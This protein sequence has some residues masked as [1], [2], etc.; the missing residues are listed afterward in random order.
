MIRR[1]QSYKDS[2]DARD[3][4]HVYKYIKAIIKFII[5]TKTDLRGARGCR[6]FGMILN[7]LDLCIETLGA[8]NKV[9]AA[10]CKSS[11]AIWTAIIETAR[12]KLKKTE[13]STI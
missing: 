11:L 3:H 10:R 4:T 8:Q 7:L 9:Q 1:R 6:P 2:V 5:L 12:Y 13:T